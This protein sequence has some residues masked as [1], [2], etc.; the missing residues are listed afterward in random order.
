LPIWFNQPPKLIPSLIQFINVRFAAESA[1]QSTGDD[2]CCNALHP[3]SGLW[4]DI[5]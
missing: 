5:S 3:V 2:L 4:L 1:I